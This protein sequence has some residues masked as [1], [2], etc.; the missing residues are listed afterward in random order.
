M[1][2]TERIVRHLRL[3]ADSEAT[4]RR[5]AL[6]LEDALRCASLPDAG[7]CLLLVRHLDLGLIAI[8]AS[9]QTLSLLLERRVA[10]AGAGW[11]HGAAPNADRADF[12]FFRDALEARY[13]LALRLADAAPCAAWYW[14]LSVPEFKPAEGGRANLRRIALA[15]AALPEAPAAVPAWIA[16]LS[17]AGVAPVLAQA[18]GPVEAAGLL[19]AAHL[20]VGAYRPRIIQMASS[21]LPQ[22]VSS[23]Q[24]VDHAEASLR[25][26]LEPA[27]AA[28]PPWVQTLARAGGFVPQGVSNMRV[29]P[30]AH[31]T[32]AAQAAPVAAAAG[33]S[34]TGNEQTFQKDSNVETPQAFVAPDTG[35]KDVHESPLPMQIEA[36]TV[37]LPDQP[38]TI[39]TEAPEPASRGGPFPDAALSAYGGLLFVLP[40]LQRLGYAAW[41]ETLLEGAAMQIAQQVLAL[42]LRRLDAPSDDP[43]WLLASTSFN[44]DFGYIDVKA[45]AIWGDPTLAAPRGSVEKDIVALAEQAQPA[46]ALARIWLIACRRWLRRVAGIG[47]ASLVMRP[48]AIG[49]TATHADVFFRLS[50]ADIRVR[51]AGIDSDPG[52]VPWLG[53]VV[54]FHYTDQLTSIPA[55]RAGRVS[56]GS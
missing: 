41:A 26:E 51:R 39:T 28:L 21:E 55:P 11:V 13:E 1:G 8:G 31:A 46:A 24:D 34:Q 33:P 9:P 27:F 7:A 43:A 19:R 37:Y 45:P 14:P 49:L 50:D 53:R 38:D 10:A 52:W 30:T 2:A 22:L 44:D 35:A 17:A 42:V 25:R 4:V 6:K 56:D 40:A 32:P 29:A 47:V 3:R 20:F 18:I 15:I 48:A 54:A 12:V 5:A 36:D 16:R 23:A